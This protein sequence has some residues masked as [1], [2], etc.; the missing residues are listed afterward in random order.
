MEA[1]YDSILDL[2]SQVVIPD[3]GQ[4]IALLPIGLAALAALWFAWTIRRFATAG[5]TRRAPAR[6]TPI[7]P[8]DLHM[9]GGSAAPFA[10]ALGAAAL[11]AGLVIGGVAILAGAAV[12]VATLLYWGREAIRDFEH[13]TRAS[14]AAGAEAR[15]LPAVV[16]AGP[17]PGVHMPG[18]SFRPILGALGTGALM[19]GLVFGGWVLA[20]GVVILV[21]TLVGWLVD[22]RAEYAQV[23]AADR[24]GHLENIPAP[25]WPRGLLQGGAVIFVLAAL[26]QAGVIPPRVAPAGGPDGS[27]GPSEPALQPATAWTIVAK[28][29]AFDVRAIA[30]PADTPFTITLDN[31]DAPGIIHDADIRQDDKTTVI[32]DQAV[33]NGG[34]SVT[35]SYDGLAAGSYVFICSIHP[36]PNMTGTITVR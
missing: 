23:E 29:I 20:A 34:Q 19:A 10:G 7:P 28:D 18:P 31:Q 16:H 5:P 24:T 22:A 25:R 33:V 11:L 35:Y 15:T 36:V 2:L 27:P 13:A 1:L 32:Q 17:P 12:L 21:A 6:L 4:L 26:I 14:H 30:V 9:P 3:W 8:P